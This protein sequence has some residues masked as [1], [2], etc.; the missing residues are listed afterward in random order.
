M[1]NTLFFFFDF[2]FICSA[3]NIWGFFFP[4][5]LKFLELQFFFHSYMQNMRLILMET[6][7]ICPF[8]INCNVLEATEPSGR[9]DILIAEEQVRGQEKKYEI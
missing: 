2:T 3:F 9:R 4:V 7:S 6:S 8:S 1:V 5:G